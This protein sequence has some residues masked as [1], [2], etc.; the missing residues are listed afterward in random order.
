MSS[1][2]VFAVVSGEYSDYSVSF[3][4]TTRELAE[5]CAVKMNAIDGSRWRGYEV[6]DMLML[7]AVPR[8]VEVYRMDANISPTGKVTAPFN[9]TADPA[10]HVSTDWDFDSRARKRPSVEV[11]KVTSGTRLSVS[12]TDKS[13]VLKAFSDRVTKMLSE[14]SL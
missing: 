10:L 3:V 9:S 13:G 12:G 6:E 7:D 14:M 5:E 1:K 2:E 4:C 8:R 11:N